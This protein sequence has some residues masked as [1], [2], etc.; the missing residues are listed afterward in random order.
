MRNRETGVLALG[1][2]LAVER[3]ASRPIRPRPTPLCG[4]PDRTGPA[5]RHRPRVVRPPG[6]DFPASRYAPR[7]PALRS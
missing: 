5:R 1:R 7:R 2:F 6:A 4:T 3:Y